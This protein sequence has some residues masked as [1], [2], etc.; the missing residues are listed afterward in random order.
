MGAG[1]SLDVVLSRGRTLLMEAARGGRVDL[2]ETLLDKGADVGDRDGDGRTALLCACSAGHVEGVKL[3]L[4]AGAGVSTECNGGHHLISYAARAGSSEIVAMLL[5]A[6]APIANVDG[7]IKPLMIAAQSFSAH[8]SDW[9]P[10]AVEETHGSID[11]EK[12][13]YMVAIMLIMEGADVFEAHTDSESGERRR[14]IDYAPPTVNLMR[15]MLLGE[16]NRRLLAALRGVACLPEPIR[17]D[18]VARMTS[19]V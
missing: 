17:R 3:L 15:D 1:A 19:A 12:R 18:I 9:H 7:A 13:S 16:M 11:W 2:M 14:A 8:I 6:D 4:A 10:P 5:H